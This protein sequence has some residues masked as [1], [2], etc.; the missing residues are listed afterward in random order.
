[1]LFFE[2]IVPGF[3]CCN[4]Q[5]FGKT[6]LQLKTTNKNLGLI[7]NTNNTQ[8]SKKD[9]ED[10]YNVN[11]GLVDIDTLEWLKSLGKSPNVY[12]YDSVYNQL[13]EIKI[14]KFDIE[15]NTNQR[16]YNISISYKIERNSLVK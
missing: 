12:K 5:V 10:E 16:N 3:C 11:S 6:H 7:I 15:T 2:D 14:D 9:I 4:F 1:M 8:T 13:R